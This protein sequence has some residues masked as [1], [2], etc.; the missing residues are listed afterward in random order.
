MNDEVEVSDDDDMTSQKK[1]A[2]KCVSEN[3]RITINLK[4]FGEKEEAAAYKYQCTLK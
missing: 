4:D 3:R 1:R 2:L